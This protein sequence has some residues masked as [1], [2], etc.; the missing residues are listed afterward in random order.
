MT[1]R[2]EKAGVGT[3]V[4]GT[5]RDWWVMGEGVQVEPC[6]PMREDKQAILDAFL[7]ACQKTRGLWDLTA[8]QYECTRERETVTALFQGKFKK[9]I[10]VRWDS[11]VA[12]LRD[13]LEGLR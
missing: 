6:E 2:M 1:K 4:G 5:D 12:M 7:I 10:N 11:G 8:L 13:V 3:T 9:V